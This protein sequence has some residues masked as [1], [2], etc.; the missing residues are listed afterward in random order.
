MF[1]GLFKSDTVV[2]EVVFVH[3][4][5]DVDEETYTASEASAINAVPHTRIYE[6]V[7]IFGKVSYLAKMS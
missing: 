1:T 6:P 3:H 5:I 4:G 2:P 7:A